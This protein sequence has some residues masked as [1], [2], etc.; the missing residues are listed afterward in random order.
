MFAE[1]ESALRSRSAE[2]GE[3]LSR[4]NAFTYAEQKLRSEKYQDVKRMWTAAMEAAGFGAWLSSPSEVD[5]FG[6]MDDG[7]RA[8]SREPPPS[9]PHDATEGR[10]EK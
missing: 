9:E 3:V 6:L 5:D 7:R 10:H 4:G 2:P 1:F 8:A